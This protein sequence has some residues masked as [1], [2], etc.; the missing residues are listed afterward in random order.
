VPF[1]AFPADVRRIVYTTDES[2]KGSTR[3]IARFRVTDRSR[4]LLSGPQ[5]GSPGPVFAGGAGNDRFRG[6]LGRR[7]LG[8]A[9]DGGCLSALGCAQGVVDPERSAGCGAM[10]PAAQLA[11]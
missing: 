10:S 9:F 6:S 7:R 1:L 3:L 8:D 11:P 4:W 2:V 5:I